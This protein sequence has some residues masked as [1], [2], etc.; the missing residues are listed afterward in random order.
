MRITAAV[1]TAPDGPPR[2]MPVD[3]DD[4][5]PGDVRVKVEACGVCHT[6]LGAVAILP[7][8]AVFGHEG[9][10][11]VEAVGPGVTK[12]KPGDRVVMTF[13]SCGGCPSCVE[14]EPAYCHAVMPLQFGGSRLDGS[15]TLRGADGT[16]VKAAFF[17]QSSFA[18]HAIA[19]ARNCVVVGEEMPAELLAPLGCGVQTG[20]GAVLNIF[21][22]KPANSLLVIGVGA[23]GLSAVLAARLAGM[24]TIIVTDVVPSRLDLA[25]EL[26]ATHAFDGRDP[27][28]LAQVQALTGGGVNYAL[29]TAGTVATAQLVVDALTLRGM[30]GI[31]TA[32]NWGSP[33]PFNV[34][35]IM[36]GKRLVGILEGGS[37][38]DRFI[39]SLIAHQKAGRFPYEKMVQRYAF[40]DI[41]QAYADFA[42]H[43]VIKPVLMMG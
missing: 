30:A 4:L 6:D 39:P 36:L 5:K 10:G 38:P 13:G 22:P 32:P 7:L 43:R 31:V 14:D 40:A 27:E 3:L 33:V 15:A 16:D 26:G 9:V 37:V 35:S 24:Q 18:T 20:A 19:T 41:A 21:R 1:T 42:A 17:Q 2:L 25:R 34:S 28:L 8:P 11:R 29:D 12:V 23:V